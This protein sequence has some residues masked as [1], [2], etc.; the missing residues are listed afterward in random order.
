MLAM[1]ELASQP[2]VMTRSVYKFVS[3]V[4]SRARLAKQNIRGPLI[5]LFGGGAVAF[6]LQNSKISC[7]RLSIFII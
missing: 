6:Q 5:K 2:L 3:L 1:D 4:C 7:K